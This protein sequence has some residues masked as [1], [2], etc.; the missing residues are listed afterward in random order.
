MVNR[1]VTGAH[2]GIRDWLVQRMSAIV[3]AVTA[4]VIV[5]GVWSHSPNTYV[6]W[7]GLLGRW[8]MWASVTL[9][10]L[11]AL[12]HAWVGVRDILMDYIKPTGIR[13]TAEVVVILALVYY[14]VW[15][16]QILWKV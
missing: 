11:G 5:I 3:M 14:A 6:L 1:V 15:A 12:L 16:L 10:T 8:W 7:K 13:L 2:Y 9:F 4:V